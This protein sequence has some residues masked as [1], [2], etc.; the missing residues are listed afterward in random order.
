MWREFWFDHDESDPRMDIVIVT[1]NVTWWVP[2][3]EGEETS[4]T[5]PLSPFQGLS[6]V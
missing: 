1:T 6:G 4:V 3:S 5:Q 2:E